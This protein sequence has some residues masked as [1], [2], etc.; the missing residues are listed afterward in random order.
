MHRRNCVGTSLLLIQTVC[1]IDKRFSVRHGKVRATY[2][3][4]LDC[5]DARGASESAGEGLG[6]P[7]AIAAAH[8]VALMGKASNLKL[9]N[10]PVRQTRAIP[11]Q[12]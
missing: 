11:L 8:S 10:T 3:R 6:K 1:C 9:T 4:A 5:E 12:D 2:V 7:N